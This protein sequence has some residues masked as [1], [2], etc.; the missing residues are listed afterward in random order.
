[1][2]FQFFGFV[3]VLTGGLQNKTL[4]FSP[5][6]TK[7]RG[8]NKPNGFFFGR[9]PV[10]N[11]NRTGTKNAK[12][13][14]EGTCMAQKKTLSSTTNPVNQ[15]RLRFFARGSVGLVPRGAQHHLPRGA[16]RGP[17][18][19]GAAAPRGG[20]AEVPHC[21]VFGGANYFCPTFFGWPH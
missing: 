10:K 9:P 16:A 8:S 19:R 14:E 21:Q 1:M 2:V 15:T 17:L 4:G 11:E 5:A 7:S 20:G 18:R 13:S 3:H 12:N 6:H